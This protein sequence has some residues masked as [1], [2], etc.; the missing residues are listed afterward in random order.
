MFKLLTI[1]CQIL[2]T[3]DLKGMAVD[4]KIYPTSPG[5]HEPSKLKETFKQSLQALGK[6]KI[7]VFYLHA[8]DRSV[9]FEDT[10]EAVNELYNAGHLYVFPMS[11]FSPHA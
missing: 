9:P 6:Y 3:L 7:R 8:P 4:T 2:A 11:G 10:L 1:F 5:A